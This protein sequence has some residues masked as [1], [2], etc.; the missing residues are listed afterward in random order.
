MVYIL[1]R[2]KEESHLLMSF[3]LFAFFVK[4][5]ERLGNGSV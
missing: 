5:E 2:V 1:Y 3:P 4:A